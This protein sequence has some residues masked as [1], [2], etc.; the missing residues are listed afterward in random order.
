MRDTKIAR[1]EEGKSKEVE[2]EIQ[3]RTL[4]GG[5]RLDIAHLSMNIR[6]I[7][8]IKQNKDTESIILF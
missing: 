5:R 3:S 2:T 7:Y 1:N 8:I 6:A 4:K